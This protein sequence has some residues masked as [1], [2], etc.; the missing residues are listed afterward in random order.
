M[1][2]LLTPTDLR[3]REGDGDGGGILEDSLMKL[4]PDQSSKAVFPPGC[5][6]WVLL[7]PECSNGSF[8]VNEGIVVSVY[9]GDI[10]S[11]TRR[12]YYKIRSSLNTKIFEEA[13]LIFGRNAPVHFYDNA[14]G[15]AWIGEVLSCDVLS[16]CYERANMQVQ[17]TVLL[18]EADHSYI[19]RKEVRQQ[20]LRFRLS[21][22]DSSIE[23]GDFNE[24][25]LPTMKHATTSPTP[26]PGFSHL[27]T[28]IKKP[29]SFPKQREITIPSWLL[30]DY[31]PVKSKSW[32][33][34]L[35]I[36]DTY[37]LLHS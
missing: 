32:S 33:I 26:P 17:Y 28:G 35:A 10:F 25:D 5:N 4:P 24:I 34:C 7:K 8:I 19:I 37:E 6:V 23:S 1:D 30:S 3:P 31:E 22:K 15:G 12:I 20:Q 11:P 14:T 2:A 27:A 36:L 21:D 13:R 29:S 9:V 16:S 18:C